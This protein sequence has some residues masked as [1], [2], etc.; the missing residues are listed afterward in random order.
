MYCHCKILSTISFKI[1]LIMLIYFHYKDNPKKQKKTSKILYYKRNWLK[2]NTSCFSLICRDIIKN[3]ST[4]NV[5]PTPFIGGM[6][7]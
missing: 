6:A 7:M 2:C 4:N 3:K 1:I 5:D